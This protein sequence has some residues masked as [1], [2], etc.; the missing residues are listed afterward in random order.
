MEGYDEGEETLESKIV[1]AL[2]F[3]YLNARPVY[4]LVGAYI[5]FDRE[6]FLARNEQRHLHPGEVIEQ[7]M[8]DVQQ[9][10]EQRTGIDTQQYM[11]VYAQFIDS[12]T[13][14]ELSEIGVQ[15]AA[16]NSR[17]ALHTAVGMYLTHHQEQHSVPGY[18][19]FNIR[20]D[21]STYTEVVDGNE[22]IPLT[23]TETVAVIRQQYILP[24]IQARKDRQHSYSEQLKEL[25]LDSVV[26]S[27]YEKPARDLAETVQYYPLQGNEQRY[28]ELIGTYMQLIYYILEEDW[29]NAKQK[30]E[31]TESKHFAF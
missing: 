3:M 21:G 10:Y 20:E 29:E 2:E 14:Q 1:Y 28:H 7:E 26:G 16:E 13:P 23:P 11:R 15:F 18:V 22:D 8:R 5:S 4:S 27:Q 30:K 9:M 31:F 17:D 24:L 25:F 12:A 6:L 19:I